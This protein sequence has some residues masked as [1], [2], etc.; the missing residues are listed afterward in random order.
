M[1]RPS[2]AMDARG[3]PQTAVEH[4][5]SEPHGELS[6]AAKEILEKACKLGVMPQRLNQP[7]NEEENQAVALARQ[8]EKLQPIE[9]HT[10]LKVRLEELEENGELAG[11]EGCRSTANRQAVRRGTDIRGGKW[12]LAKRN[13]ER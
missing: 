6:P 8:I 13:Q 11:R 9:Q 10:I 3:F 5:A 7:K 2:A 4:R 12:T 1:K